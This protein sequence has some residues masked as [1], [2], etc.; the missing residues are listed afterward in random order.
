M[1]NLNITYLWRIIAYASACQP[2][3]SLSIAFL[4]Y[5][6]LTCNV[7]V[8]YAESMPS[9]LGASTKFIDFMASNISGCF[10][11]KIALHYLQLIVRYLRRNCGSVLFLVVVILIW[12][13][14]LCPA[15][16]DQSAQ[17]Y[18][19]ASYMK[20]HLQIQVYLIIT[21]LTITR[22]S[23]QQGHVLAPKWL[24]SLLF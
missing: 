4:T 24:F 23:L 7:R 11:G 18:R 20:P 8:T 2:M 22:I 9:V 19:L 15:R 21:P 13:S 12:P 17:L 3:L 16:L 6:G 1:G 10:I 14:L 5:E